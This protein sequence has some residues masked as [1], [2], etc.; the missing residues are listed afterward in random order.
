MESLCSI[1]IHAKVVVDISKHVTIVV[2]NYLSAFI[3][4]AVLVDLL[5]FFILGLTPENS[6]PGVPDCRGLPFAPILKIILPD[7]FFKVDRLYVLSGS[8]IIISSSEM[9][10]DRVRNLCTI[11]QLCFLMHLFIHLDLHPNN[12]LLSFQAFVSPYLDLLFERIS[13]SDFCFLI[14]LHEILVDYF[15]IDAQCLCIIK[16]DCLYF[17]KPHRK[18]VLNRDIGLEFVLRDS[19]GIVT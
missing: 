11:S 10:L 13:K 7:A 4:D 12:Y 15:N 1:E 2:D 17:F 19:L 3:F 9:G 5:V 8:N 14:R 16:E 18:N 6:I